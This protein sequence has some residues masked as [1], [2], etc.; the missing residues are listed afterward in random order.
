M[1]VPQTPHSMDTD[2]GKKKR[3]KA[4]RRA[5]VGK[6]QKSYE[7]GNEEVSERGCWRGG[8]QCARVR[9]L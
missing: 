5:Y 6:I 8:R 4:D 9:D 2:P 1:C 7:G 3:N